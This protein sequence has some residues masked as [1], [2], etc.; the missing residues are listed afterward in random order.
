[1]YILSAAE[2]REWDRFTIQHEPVSSIDLME[3]AAR[4][5]FEWISK[6]PW[7]EKHFRIFCGKGNNGGDGLAIA[8]ML[9]EKGYG[10]TVYI[11]EFGKI[12]SQDFQ[13]NLQRLH[14]HAVDIHFIQ[15]QDNF[16]LIDGNDVVV[17]A[18]FGTGLNKP[19][20]QLAA[21]LVEHLNRSNALI[22]SIDLPSGLF[23]DASSRGNAAV[24][25]DYTLSF[26]CYKPALMVQENAPNIGEV[27]LL[28]IGLHP[29]FLKENGFSRQLVDE[30]LAKNI[31]RPRRAFAHKG[32]YGHALLIAGSYGKV[33]AA[34]LATK[35][36]LH[37]GAG[38]TTVYTPKCGYSIL[39]IT[40]P[41]AM[42]MTDENENYLSSLPDDI[43]KY[44]V[45][46]I[47][48]GIDIK[49]ET[50][51]MISFII[52]RYHKPLVI[53]ADG[54]NCLSLQQDL[55]PHLPPQSVLT[56]HPKEFD[57]LFGNHQ[58]DFDRI[59]TTTQKA[60]ELNVII[61]L[62]SHHTVI[63][64]PEGETYFNSTGNAGMAK[65]GSGDVLTGMITALLAQGYK[66]AQAA[67]LGV[68]LHGSSGDLAAPVLS[69]EAMVAGDLIRFIS[70]AFLKLY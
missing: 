6:Q 31:F 30:V 56:P 59:Q 25:A 18:L 66:P 28:D 2:V 63:A 19:L 22:V 37:S 8:R 21:Q 38:L 14:Q 24:K 70:K 68:Y 32:N 45:I 46:G 5:C 4:N 13:I 39:Q 67:V 17:D 10:V 52:R 53:D 16:P 1:M 47:G 64:T 54:L 50:Q 35:S 40:A 26:Q 3:R 57:R 9:F 60:A 58:N 34:V 42:V 11:L 55:L 7:Q 43:E 15:G 29:R 33:G 65:G 12:G 23:V 61:V 49:D 51:K 69:Q 62:K 27:Y 41:E 36:C 48:P 44:A 20:R